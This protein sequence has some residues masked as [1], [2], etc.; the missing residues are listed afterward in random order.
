MR[1]V[2]ALLPLPVTVMIVPTQ[3][4]QTMRQM[5]TATMV[6]TI[7]ALL[8]LPVTA[9]IVPTQ[10]P[11]TMRQMETAT[12]VITIMVVNSNRIPTEVICMAG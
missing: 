9:M 6:I 4:P 7:M 3:I 2:M 8:P 12:M 1:T 10:I 5:E 11:Q